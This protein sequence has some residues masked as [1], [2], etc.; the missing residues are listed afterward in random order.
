MSEPPFR[1][2]RLSRQIAGDAAARYGAVTLLIVVCLFA[3]RFP[4]F[5]RGLAL[6]GL[7]AATGMWGWINVASMRSARALHEASPYLAA[8]PG[9]AEAILAAAL[10]RS[11]LQRWVRL[12]LYHRLA[13][14]RLCQGRAGE[15]AAICHAVLSR[16]LGAARHARAPLLLAFAEAALATGDVWGAYAALSALDGEEIDLA[17]GLRRLAIQGRYHLAAGVPSAE[18][19]R[20]R[21]KVEAAEMLPAEASAR[22]HAVLSRAAAAAGATGLSHWLEA[23]ADLLGGAAADRD[24]QRPEPEAIAELA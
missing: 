4:A 21:A 22:R 6:L 19:A 23:R 15:A 10:Q 17:H 5:G 14:V 24:A 16:R 8:D 1:P 11:G 13:V 7:V 18:L 3:A 12:L 2:A 20:A 9:R